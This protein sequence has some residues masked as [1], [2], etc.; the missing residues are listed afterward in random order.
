MIITNFYVSYL[1]I[2]R[3]IE[4]LSIIFKHGMR[5][6]WSHSLIG[7][8][9]RKRRIRDCKP[10]YST[11]ERLRLVIE[12]L[13]P[14]YVKFGQIL[15]DRPDVVSD[16][17]RLELKKL[18]SAAEPFSNLV[19]IN[20]I[21][22]E[23]RANVDEVFSE[24]G[25]Q[26]IA[27]A[28]IGQVYAAKLRSGEQVIVKVRRPNVEQ[29]IKLDIYI[30]RYLAAKLANSYPEM[31]AIN[32]IAVVDE[33]G[34]SIMAELDYYNEA[35]NTVRFQE[36]FKDSTI[37]YIPKVFLE[38]TTKR[39]L[40]QERIIG[41]TPDDN[42]KLIANGLD[43]VQISLNGTDVLLKMIF[44]D[45]FFHADPHAGNMFIMPGN[46]VGLI[47]F[48]MVGILR[49]RDM[50]FLANISI[51]FFKRNEVTIADAMI[52]LCGIRYFDRHDDLVFSIQQMLGQYAHLPL[53]QLDYSKMMQQCI[54]V[55]TKFGLQI[56]S[57][58]FM[59]IKSL[60][61]IQKVSEELNPRIPFAELIT[62]YATEVVKQKISPRTLAA[63]I[64]E[65]GM[66]YYQLLSSLPTDIGEIIY[67]IKQGEIKHELKFQDRAHFDRSLRSV[68]FRLSYAILLVGMFLG[69]VGLLGIRD[70]VAYAN[71]AIWTS[72]VLIGLFILRWLFNRR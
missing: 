61:T 21:E 68:S 23:L 70:D 71:F 25:K 53:E 1:K 37:C 26:C 28:S 6:L 63:N 16:R 8:Y 17:F 5:E 47:D 67:K 49:P 3:A 57:G 34:E 19:A 12:N 64:Y 41:I 42:A 24:F 69:S 4:I 35:A 66:S 50:E 44:K 43:P 60:A 62:P 13:G 14:T 36:M 20:I 38:Y 11:Q 7:K 65:L 45:G 9:V 54:N 59:L 15:A 10:V 31:A 18:Q 55:I 27:S 40:V 22:N 29:K 56:P 58:I 72:S 2:I 32:I 30:M 51:G 46:V 48:G 39:V 33:F 52:K